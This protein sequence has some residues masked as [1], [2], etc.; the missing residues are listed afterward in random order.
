VITPVASAVNEFTVLNAVATDSP[1]L[2]TSGT[3]ANVDMTFTTK[4]ASVFNF[5]TSSASNS[6][7]IRI[8]DDT[9]GNYVGF[10]SAA[11]TT[12]YTVTMPPAQSS[13]GQVLENNGSGALGWVTRG[14]YNDETF[15]VHDDGDSS[16]VIK[17]ELDGATGSTTTTLVA[18][19]TANRSITLFDA[20]DTVLGRNTT[21]I[22]TNKTITSTS[23]NVAAKGLH[24]ATTLVDVASSAAPTIGQVLIANSGTVASWQTFVFGS[25]YMFAES[26][27][28]SSTTSPTYQNKVTLSTGLIPAGTYRIGWSYLYRLNT[29]SRDFGARVQVDN[30]TTVWEARVETKDAGSDQRVSASGFYHIALTNATHIIDLDYRSANGTNTAYIY[31]AVLEFWRVA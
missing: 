28:E 10:K 1:E 23:N 21:D 18:S 9:G 4:G 26:L 15:E 5:N 25:E 3:D 19:Q 22:L 31:T 14:F 24:T 20:D 2:Q 12:S 7:E 27:G 30:T 16:K 13:A 11:V 8:L 6:A 29:A 17:F